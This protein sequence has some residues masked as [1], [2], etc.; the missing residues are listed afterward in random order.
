MIAERTGSQVRIAIE[1]TEAGFEEWDDTVLFIRTDSYH[2]AE[3]MIDYLNK[4]EMW[5]SPWLAR[6]IKEDNELI[7]M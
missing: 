7:P 4:C 5:V 6:L 1:P 2:A 3:T